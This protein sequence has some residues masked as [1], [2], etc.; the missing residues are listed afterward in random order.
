MNSVHMGMPVVDTG[1]TWALPP[2]L[3]AMNITNTTVRLQ[4]DFLSD[5]MPPIQQ[6]VLQQVRAC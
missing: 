5:P 4:A 2:T 3:V 1:T 6:V